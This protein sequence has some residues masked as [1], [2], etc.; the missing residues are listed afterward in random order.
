MRHYET[1]F[2]RSDFGRS[3]ARTLDIDVMNDAVDISAPPTAETLEREA[4]LAIERGD[5]AAAFEHWRTAAEMAPANAGHKVACAAE[6]RELG[7]LDEAVLYCRAALQIRPDL[8]PAHN[9]L[10]LALRRLGAHAEALEAF[11]SASDLDLANPWF[12]LSVAGELTELGQLDAAA[13]TYRTILRDRPDFAHA[14]HG[15]GQLLR[16][17]GERDAALASLEAATLADPAN[18]WFKL[19]R[20]GALR[21]SGRLDEA[22]GI[23]RALVA[24]APEFAGAWNEL[25]Q[26]LR[27]SGDAAGSA[28]ALVAAARAEPANPWFCTSAAAALRD[29]GRLDEAIEFCRAALRARADFAPA[30]N[31]CGLALR[32]RGD[33]AE[34]LEMFRSAS[35][36]EPGNPWFRLSAAGELSELGEL[37]AAMET[38]QSLARERPELAPA[39]N[40]LGQ[41]YRRRGETGLA[42]AAFRAATAAEPDNPWFQVSVATA[43]R[44]LGRLDEAIEMCRTAIAKHGQFAPALHELGL[45]LAQRGEFAEA[46]A[47]LLAAVASEP[48]NPWFRISLAALRRS[49]GDVAAANAEYRELLARNPDFGAAR[50]G[51]AQILREEGRS[52]EAL[53]EFEAAAHAD[54]ANPHFVNAIVA[55]LR[56]LGRWP[57]AEAR[58]RENVRRHPRL[59]APL[60]ELAHCLSGASAPTAAADAL[61]QALE[62]E[63]G[64]ASARCLLANEYVGAYRLDEAEA[65]YREALRDEPARIEALIGLGLVA[66]FR[67]DRPE[68]LRRFRDAAN[69]GFSPWAVGELAQEYVQAG[70]AEAA[71]ATLAEA[72]RRSPA[73]RNLRMQSGHVERALNAHENALAVF[74]SV[75]AAYPQFAPAEVEIAKQLYTLGRTDLAM[76]AIK[77]ALEIDPTD[78]GAL[79][80]LSAQLQ[81]SDRMEDAAAA[82]R[83]SA[84]RGSRQIWTRL[85]L[86]RVEAK[87]GRLDNALTLLDGVARGLGEKPEIASVKA[88]LLQ[89]AGL[90][91]DAAREL[92]RALAAFPGNLALR[93]QRAALATASE[94]FALARRLLADDP[95]LGEKERRDAAWP[96]A[97]LAAAEY[98]FAGALALAEEAIALEPSDPSRSFFA[99]RAALLDFRL[100]EAER[101][102]RLCAEMNRSRT[103]IQGVSANPM[104]SHIGH[105][106]TEWRL[107]RDA[108]ERTMDARKHTGQARIEALAQ[109]VAEF[110]DYTPAALALFVQL[111]RDDLLTGLDSARAQSSSHGIPRRIAQFWDEDVPPPDVERLCDTWRINNL[112]CDYR[113]FSTE[114]ANQFLK[115]RCDRSVLAAFQ[116]AREPAQKADIF[117]LAYLFEEGG[118]WADAD[119][120][121]VAPIEMLVPG[122]RE[123]VVYQEDVGSIGNN[124]LAAAP[125][126][127]VIGAALELAVEAINRGDAD[128][129]WLS[130][131]PGLITR[132]LAASIPRD[133]GAFLQGGDAPLIL[134]RGELYRATRIHCEASYKHTVKHW[135]RTAFVRSRTRYAADLDALMRL[136]GASPDAGAATQPPR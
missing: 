102:A 41:I 20:A 53:A 10:G 4:R 48:S 13:E 84:T 114:T 103:A 112:D 85:A 90:F 34:A 31:E 136:A 58:A 134:R 88:A 61:R 23:C 59:A 113:R 101:N 44:E 77:A 109:A 125:R 21:E 16:R 43:T 105:L 89:D 87:L 78:A 116:R 132:V 60:I 110:P 91:E 119:D 83:L 50:S 124:F 11:R 24:Q 74:R 5:H 17:R 100:D 129:L 67:G 38:F 99:G 133:I 96:K 92:D 27:L 130:T 19:T 54:P 1:L 22:V 106:L 29:F 66:R 127:P 6:L 126:Q 55:Q 121:C 73:D 62:M 120:R 71:R 98:D 82:L 76:G 2:S 30:L 115:E 36:V 47:P 69:A 80:L 49:L 131:G 39:H 72:L 52:E 86:A 65:L 35:A 14:H 117:R 25:G 46:L 26:A 3:R 135:S 68:A 40:G 9:E 37:G 107:D 32:R 70:D 57:E 108:L 42:L 12:R 51:L 81:D 118:F 111:R 64:N 45:A 33:H 97:H 7:R 93:R 18:A 56:A 79:D 94:D 95:G 123:L 63:P 8:T 75:A 104:Q 128:I 15:L 122:G 28:E